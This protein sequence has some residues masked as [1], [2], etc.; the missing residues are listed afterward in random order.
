MKRLECDQQVG[1]T[2]LKRGV[3]EIHQILRQLVA[4]VT[5]SELVAEDVEA[6]EA[7]LAFFVVPLALATFFAVN[8]F[9]FAG[10]S[11]SELD[12][13]I[14]ISA[15]AFPVGTIET[16]NG[17]GVFEIGFVFHAAVARNT[18]SVEVLEVDSE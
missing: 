17:F 8:K 9:A 18:L 13:E 2:S 14:E 4:L 3:N 7:I 6:R 15:N 11:S 1:H 16:K 12:A 10:D 5:E